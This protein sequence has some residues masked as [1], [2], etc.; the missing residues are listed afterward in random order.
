MTTLSWWFTY[1]YKCVSVCCLHMSMYVYVWTP[2]DNNLILFMVKGGKVMNKIPHF[3]HVLVRSC[4]IL[5]VK[6]QLFVCKM[7]YCLV[8][9]PWYCYMSCSNPHVCIMFLEAVVYDYI[10]ISGINHHVCRRKSQSVAGK[11]SFC[12]VKSWFLVVKSWP[13]HSSWW[14][15]ETSLG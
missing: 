14:L 9:S 3:L 12:L 13:P 6:T 10:P 11:S 5:Q 4:W 7:P 8:K 15:L 1:I 2:H